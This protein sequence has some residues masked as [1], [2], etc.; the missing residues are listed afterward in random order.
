[1]QVV[2]LLVEVQVRVLVGVRVLQPSR[3]PGAGSGRAC[4][5]G[6]GVGR[7]R[8]REAQERVGERRQ[9]LGLRALRRHALHQG[10][11]RQVRW[12]HA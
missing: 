3:T 11:L 10:R 12:R 8:R 7:G 9:P 5:A 2:G 6:A 4:R 1:M